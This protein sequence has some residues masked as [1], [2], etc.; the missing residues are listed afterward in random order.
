[1]EDIFNQFEKEPDRQLP[2]FFLIDQSGSMFGDKIGAVNN[3]MREL[4]E[5]LKNEGVD[6]EED[7][8]IKLSILSFS[9]GCQWLS[10]EPQSPKEIIGV[11]SNL[12]ADGLTDLGEAL[13]ELDKKMSRKEFIKSVSATFAPLVIILTDGYPTDN[14]RKGLSKCMENKWFINARRIALP[15]GSY[16]DLDVLNEFTG[17]KELVLNPATTS[18][19][20]RKA[21]KKIVLGASKI[22]SQSR[23]KPGEGGKLIDPI[24][25][26]VNETNEDMKNDETVDPNNLKKDD[27]GW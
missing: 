2:I 14:W 13:E 27:G 17:N 26:L 23:L 20:L 15:I 1:M 21:L 8:D 6:G 25:E 4:L 5:E 12:Q 22:G 19:Q 11:W 7:A 24:I 16:V 18:A 3:T 9:T 10:A